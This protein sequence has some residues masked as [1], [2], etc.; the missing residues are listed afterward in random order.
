MNFGVQM[1]C[2][3][4][5]LIADAAVGDPDTLWRRIPH[6]VVV[7]GKLIKRLD[8][9]L[10]REA[11]SAAVRRF[12]GA[13]ALGILLAAAGATGYALHLAATALPFGFVLE[14]AV[15]AVMLA[16]NSL[17]GHV[18]DVARGLRED[19]LKGARLA[20]ARIVGRDPESLDEASVSRAAI[21]SLAE[22]FSDGVVAPVFWYVL[23]GLPGL[24]ACKALNTAD[25]MIGHRTERHIDFGWASARLDDLANLPA[26]RLTAGLILLGAL[27]RSGT[28]AAGRGWNA[29]RSSALLHRSPN[30]GWPEA[31][32]AGVL[33]VALA[34][35]RCYGETVV[36]D[37]W[38]NAE[39]R[40]GS[41]AED[42]DAALAVYR[43]ACVILWLLVAGLLLIA[44]IWSAL[45][46]LPDFRS[47]PVGLFPAKDT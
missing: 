32:M 29:V 11:D 16:Q 31:A 23:L 9:H 43:N 21:E 8:A 15:I 6:P 3:L 22:N 35:P 27:F 34:G 20:V 2:L 4:A 37:A 14:T 41:G 19:G 13:I 28:A 1:A 38:M 44:A 12:A 17:A 36:H 46:A 40:R 18:G 30:A 42:I 24:L 5:G 33:G 39:G 7:A 25:S 45:S 47:L 10:N 26:S